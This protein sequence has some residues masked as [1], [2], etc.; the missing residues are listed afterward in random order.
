MK[1]RNS[2]RAL[3][4]CA[5]IGFALFTWRISIAPPDVYR[6]ADGSPLVIN[7]RPVIRQK[8]WVSQLVWLVV[9]AL[10]NYALAAKP[11]KPKPAAIDDFDIPQAVQGAPFAMI[12][13]EVEDKSPVVAWYGDLTSKPIKKGKK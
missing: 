11:P 3:S 8:A 10:I 9:S 12:F 4:L 5:A 6:K 2:L 1:L 13:G 7:G